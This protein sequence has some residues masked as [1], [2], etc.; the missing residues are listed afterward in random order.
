M[1]VFDRALVRARRERAAARL[2][3]AD[4]LFREAAERLVER[5]DDVTRRFPCRCTPTRAIRGCP[6]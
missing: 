4:F 6:G 1:T 3:D 5:L 2:G